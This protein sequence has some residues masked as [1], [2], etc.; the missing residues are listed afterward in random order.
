MSN[1]V[2]IQII[3]QAGTG[4]SAICELIAK[5]LKEHNFKEITTRDKEAI[6]KLDEKWEA[7]RLE[8]VAMNTHAT[9]ETVQAKRK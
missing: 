6:V 4:K 2:T 3:G 5:T 1:N 7:K 9:I 8:S